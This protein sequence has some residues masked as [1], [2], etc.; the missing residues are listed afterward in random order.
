MGRGVSI[1][2]NLMK[3][4]V[5]RGILAIVLLFPNVAISQASYSFFNYVASVGL[6][7]PVFDAA[8]NRLFGDN[9]VTVLYGGLTS[10]DLQLATAGDLITSM[11]PV[12]FIRIYDGNSGYFA[13]PGGVHI[14]TVPGGGVAWLQLRA[15]D[16]RLG[17]TYDEVA[18]LG[19]G[20]YGESLLF[21]ARGG[22]PVSLTP[23]QPLLGLQSFSLVPEPST[24]ALLLGGG[25][26]VWRVRKSR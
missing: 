1:S 10:N 16:L 11:D 23:P 25:W 5:N 18:V 14:T 3:T 22:D 6:D 20:G 9:Y 26:L 7:A 21:Q 24:W 15:W 12:P 4:L 13:R 17:Q 19:I 2:I 8:G